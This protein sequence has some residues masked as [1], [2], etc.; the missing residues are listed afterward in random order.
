MASGRG[1]MSAPPSIAGTL[2]ALLA[3]LGHLTL[4]PPQNMAKVEYQRVL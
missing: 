3:R 1:G 2:T 4:L